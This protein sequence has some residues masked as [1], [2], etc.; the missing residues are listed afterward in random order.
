MIRGRSTR[1]GRLAGLR[2][3]GCRCRILDSFR[4]R[5]AHT[6]VLQMITSSQKAAAAGQE[7]SG[8]GR[9]SGAAAAAIPKPCCPQRCAGLPALACVHT[10]AALAP[11]ATNQ[12]NHKRTAPVLD[13][14]LALTASSSATSASLSRQPSAPAI[15][16]TCGRRAGPGGCSAAR[17]LAAA[18]AAGSG[19][20][21]LAQ[22]VSLEQARCPAAPAAAPA[23]RSS[24]P[25][26]AARPCSCRGQG[27]L[28]RRGR[29]R[30]FLHSWQA[31]SAVL[32][33]SLSRPAESARPAPGLHAGTLAP[34][35]S[36]PSMPAWH[37][38]LPGRQAC[39]PPS[40]EAPASHG[41]ADSHLAQAPQALPCSLPAPPAHRR[42][43]TWSS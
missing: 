24:R 34:H 39:Q 3:R 18:A 9:P 4:R 13:G 21:P 11:A 1:D 30:G 16:A 7:G 35:A 28:W 37:A 31:G 43:L 19:R 33:L 29:R 10:A 5:R 41:T 12:A 14:I 20:S 8:N 26:S 6:D 36:M 38:R 17:R 27:G 40:Q 25:G 32:P 42:P 23:P 22:A 2:W 15:S